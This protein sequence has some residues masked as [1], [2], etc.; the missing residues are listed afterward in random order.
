MLKWVDCDDDGVITRR[1]RDRRRDHAQDEDY[2]GDADVERHRHRPAD[3]G[4]RR[5]LAH[6]HGIPV[7]VDG[8]QGRRAS[9]END[10]QRPSA[11]DFYVMTGHKLYGPTGIGVLYAEASPGSRI[12]RRS[13]VAAR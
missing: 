9:P 8:S 2:R 5:A 11:P 10:V 3:Q 4:D 6:A 1:R 7:L 13:S 12:C